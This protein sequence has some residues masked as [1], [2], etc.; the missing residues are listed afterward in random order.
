[1]AHMGVSQN[2][3]YSLGVPVKRIILFRGLYWA[4]PILGNYHM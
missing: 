2:W 1:M 3:R 4:P